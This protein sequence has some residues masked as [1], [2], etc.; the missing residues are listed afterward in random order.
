MLVYGFLLYINVTQ[1]WEIA[2]LSNVAS[3]RETPPKL[4]N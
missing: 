2:D 1:L 3:G 4:N